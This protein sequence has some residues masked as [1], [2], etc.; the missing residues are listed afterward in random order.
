MQ[1]FA[2]SKNLASV[3]EWPTGI[4]IILSDL[5]FAEQVETMR[6]HCVRRGG[7]E[8]A[9]LVSISVTSGAA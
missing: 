6:R 5:D 9:G 8:R 4:L 3:A 2:M 1:A 7:S